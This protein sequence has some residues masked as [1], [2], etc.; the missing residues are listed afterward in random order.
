MYE[1]I[2]EDILGYFLTEFPLNHPASRVEVV[3]EE[4][5]RSRF[6]DEWIEKCWV[7]VGAKIIDDL[8]AEFN[9]RDELGLSVR[10]QLIDD[11]GSEVRGQAMPGEEALYTFQDALLQLTDVEFERLAAR[12]LGWLGCQRTWVTPASHDEGL[13]AFGMVPLTFNCVSADALQFPALYMLAQAKHY[14]KE[15]VHTAHIREFVGASVLAKH[16]IYSAAADKYIELDN[17]PFSPLALWIIFSGEASRLT[18]GLANSSGVYLLSSYDLL[19]LF[20]NYCVLLGIALPGDAAVM[21]KMLREA[22]K[23]IPVAQ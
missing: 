20:Q 18:R 13:D 2:R 1:G 22:I 16:R 5:L 11:I 3:V 9:R 6:N 15:T 12:I 8:V 19:G 23:D 4:F 17:R 7:D 14:N 21:L 10:Y